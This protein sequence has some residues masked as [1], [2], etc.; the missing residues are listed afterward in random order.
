[1]QKRSQ[2]LQSLQDK[3]RKYIKEAC[4]GEEEMRKANGRS[5]GKTSALRGQ[6]II[7]EDEV[8]SLQAGEERRG[9]C[10]SQAN[11]CCFDPAVVEQVFAR[12]AA[13]TEHLIHAFAGRVQQKGS[14]LQPL[15]SK[16]QRRRRERRL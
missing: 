3:K 12:G 15:R 1:M 11:G 10:V 2:K 16:R 4:A 14:R 13:H 6:Q 5:A 9:R 7:L 8:Q